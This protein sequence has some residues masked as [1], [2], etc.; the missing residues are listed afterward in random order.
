MKNPNDIIES[1]NNIDKARIDLIID[2]VFNRE[3]IG[4]CIVGRDVEGITLD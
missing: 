1:I 2:K 4:V 3:N